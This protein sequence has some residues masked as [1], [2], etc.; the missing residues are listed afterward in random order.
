MH[1]TPREA[2]CDLIG[3]VS[4]KARCKYVHGQNGDNDNHTLCKITKPIET[5]SASPKSV[6]FV[7]RINIGTYY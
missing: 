4:W 5:V 2:D 6:H 1:V 3:Y 7:A